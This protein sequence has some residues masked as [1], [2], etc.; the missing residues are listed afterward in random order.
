MKLSDALKNIR[1]NTGAKA[2]SISKPTDYLDTGS[3]ALNRVLTGDIHKGF[4][5]GRISTLFG[6]SQSGKSLIAANTAVRALKDNKVD[7][8]IIFDSEGGFPVDIF[9]DAGIDLGEEDDPDCPVQHINVHSV[10]DCAVK[11]ISTYDMLVKAHDEWVKDPDNN[12]HI[13]VLCILDSYGFLASDKLVSDAVDKDKMANDMGITAKLKNNMMR[14]LV[15]RVCESDCTLL[16]INH[17]YQDPAAMFASKIHQMGGGKGI[18]YASHVVLQCE[19]VFVKA[20]DNDHLT[21]LEAD[22]ANIGFYKGNRLKCFTTKNRVSKPMYGAEIYVDFETGMSKYDG[23]IE[24][25]VKMGFLQDVRG[26]YVCPTYSEKKV[27]YRD[28]ITK[29]EIWNTFIEDFNKKSIDAMK[30]SNNTS[31]MLDEMDGGVDLAADEDTEE[32]K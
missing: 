30:Y 8:V 13:R 2:L 3:Y 17:E 28:L 1:K 15:M 20:D 10:E 26:G 23:L 31:R 5:V 29:D 18:E 32:E 16:V 21:G 7:K 11:M 4:P 22:G 6:L 14:G 9:A 12:D 19:K 27:T 24:E 25:A